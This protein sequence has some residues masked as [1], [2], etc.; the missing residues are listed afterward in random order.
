[1][2]EAKPSRASLLA[3]VGNTPLVRLLRLAPRTSAAIYVKLEFMNPSGST[4]DRLAAA[5]IAD[6]EARGVLT[7]GGTIIESTSGNTGISLAMIGSALGYKV[8]IVMPADAP[9]E[10][11]R[12]L[13]AFGAEIVSSPS[14]QG[15]AGA[16]ALAQRLASERGAFLV[17]QFSNPAGVRAHQEGTGK[18]ILAAL[19]STPVDAFV[20]GVGTGATLTGAGAALRERHPAVALIAVEPSRSP[21]LSKGEAGPHRIPGLGPSFYPPLLRKELLSLLIGITDEQA[22]ITAANLAK[23]EGLFAGL[24]SGANVVAALLVAAELGTGKTVVTV[25]P[26][27]GER[28]LRTGL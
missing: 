18:E 23:D 1:M 5:V 25:L 10:T 24:S 13:A 4:K 3:A 2:A 27:S 9:E 16:T 6:A 26:D 8:V 14:P 12:R 15:M 11:R 22:Q 21:I 19:G 20:A 7:P 17:N 28:Y